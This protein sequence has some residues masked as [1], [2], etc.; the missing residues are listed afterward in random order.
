MKG[1]AVSAILFLSYPA[2]S[3]NPTC[4]QKVLSQARERG[5]AADPQWL[6]LLHYRRT[7]FRFRSQADG[8]GFFI[9]NAGNTEPDAELE[10]LAHWLCSGEARPTGHK[11]LKSLPARCQFPARERF[12]REKLNL[13]EHPWPEPGCPDLEEWRQRINPS[14]VTLVFSSFYPNNPSSVFGHTLLRV[15][16]NKIGPVAVDSPLLSY[17]INYAA[18]ETSSNPVKYAIWGVIGGFPGEFA[19]LPYYYKVREYSDIESRDIWEYGLD[20]T[21]AEISRLIDH[22][23]EL[24]FTYFDYFYF[25][26]NCSYHLLTALEAAIPRLDVSDGLPFWV[27]PSDTIKAVTSVP[28]LV[29]RIEYRP[30]VYRQF[31]F[32]YGRVREKP[33]ARAAFHRLVDGKSIE[34]AVLPPEELALVYDAV[35]DYWDFRN[36]RELIDEKS[37]QALKKQEFLVARSR[38]P[39]TPPLKVPVDRQLQPDLSHGSMRYGFSYGKRTAG[40]GSEFGQLDIRFAF[41]DFLDYSQGVPDNSDINFFRVKLRTLDRFADPQVES[42]RIVDIRLL[43]PVNEFQKPLSWHFSLGGDRTGVYGCDNCF[44]AASVMEVGGALEWAGRR[45]LTYALGGGQVLYGA[46]F[47]TPEL[48]LVPRLTAGTRWRWNRH[49]AHV[50]EGQWGRAFGHRQISQ[51]QWTLESRYIFN[52]GLA[53]GVTWSKDQFRDEQILFNLFYYR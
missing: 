32:R 13:G 18:T 49:W 21:A 33:E 39:V 22:I 7:T 23:W 34:P 10:A 4:E 15:N 9:S 38:L 35:L 20:I 8:N 14:D 16:R 46:A 19:A 37:A 36:F 45:L 51:R 25:T 2:F 40:A 53:A 30:S 29:K 24:G 47:E 44:A 42:A 50:I 52:Y 17:G 48:K 11:R 12:L 3:A 31:L 6:R 41:H 5:L 28:G 26:E 1:M 43:A 27:I